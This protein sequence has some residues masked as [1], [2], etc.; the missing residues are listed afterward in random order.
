LRY[1]DYGF[2]NP[3]KR[4]KLVT[5]IKSLQEQKVPVMAI[6]TQAHVNVSTKF[7]VMDQALTEIEALGLPIHV[8]ELDVNI[9]AGGQ[10]STSANI[11][12]S[13]DANQGGLIHDANSV[14]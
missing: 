12:A 3:A 13:S 14:T 6:G 8:T 2:E 4:R 9:A 7:E 5:L 1:N 11:A 10:R